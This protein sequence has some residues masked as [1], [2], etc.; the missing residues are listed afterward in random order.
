MGNTGAITGTTGG[1]ASAPL[2]KRAMVIIHGAG[3]AD[4]DYSAP[5]VERIKSLINS[6]DAKQFD[7]LEVLYAAVLNSPDWQTARTAQSARAQFASDMFIKTIV[8]ENMATQTAKL[9]IEQLL[10]NLFGG[11]S[12]NAIGAEIR[13]A[14]LSA[15]NALDALAK[16][17]TG[18][19]L[20]EWRDTIL[21]NPTVEDVCF[22]LDNAGFRNDVKATLIAKLKEAQ[23]YEDVILVSHSLGTVVAFDVL[24][25]WTDPQLHISTWFTMGCPLKK[26]LALDKALNLQ[27][28]RPNQLNNS[29]VSRWFN[30]YNSLDFVAN[31]LSPTFYANGVCDI[32]VQP[33]VPNNLDPIVAHDYYANDNA[34]KLIAEFIQTL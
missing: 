21:K 12:L 28:N 19:S 10:G 15:D 31:P 7:R 27:P 22:Y 16:K 4:P 6:P 14:F 2:V 34:L 24:N 20:D 8:Q 25:E 9:P 29:R 33:K 11:N 18:S 13:A 30:V 3:D 26:I 5:M 17:I 1:S 32:F 23:Q